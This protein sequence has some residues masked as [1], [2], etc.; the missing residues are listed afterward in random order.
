MAKKRIRF[1]ALAMLM[2]IVAVV[3]L[4]HDQATAAVWDTRDTL[5]NKLVINVVPAKDTTVFFRPSYKYNHHKA[6]QSYTQGSFWDYEIGAGYNLKPVEDFSLGLAVFFKQEISN[7]NALSSPSKSYNY[8][9]KTATTSA[10]DKKGNKEADPVYIDKLNFD[11]APKYKLGDFTIYGRYRAECI[12]YVGNTETWTK[13]D[14]TG[15]GKRVGYDSSEAS[16]LSVLSR[17]QLGLEWSITK[18]FKIFVDNEIWYGTIEDNE[19]K[20]VPGVEGKIMRAGVGVND[21]G[22]KY[23]PGTAYNDPDKYSG[24]AHGKYFTPHGLVKNRFTIGIGAKL[25]DSI[26]MKLSWIADT[27]Y[28][29]YHNPNDPVLANNDDQR[30]SYMYQATYPNTMQ[31]IS[32]VNWVYIELAYKID[33]TK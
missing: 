14:A 3:G 4:S 25:T 23:N 5:W 33:L 12:F 29:P 17:I 22:T 26:D 30:Y 15:T 9:T 27:N 32:I 31:V 2:A 7:D 16:G 21:D 13:L 10:A 20:F 8:I 28:N 18:K 6:N 24:I 11:I 1:I 19:T